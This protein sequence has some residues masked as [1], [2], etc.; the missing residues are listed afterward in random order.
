MKSSC[1][2]RF[3]T[4]HPSLKQQGGLMIIHRVAGVFTMEWLCRPGSFG[5]SFYMQ[6]CSRKDEPGMPKTGILKRVGG[7]F[8]FMLKLLLSFLLL[9]MTFGSKAQLWKAKAANSFNPYDSIGLRHNEGLEYSKTQFGVSN[10]DKTLNF[11]RILYPTLPSQETSEIATAGANSADTDSTNYVPEYMSNA[12][13]TF[14]SQLILIIDQISDSSLIDNA[15]LSIKTL[16]A[17]VLNSD[18]PEKEKQSLLCA[19]SV[20]RHSLYYWIENGGNPNDISGVYP[21]SQQ[22]VEVNSLASLSEIKDLS[23]NS[24]FNSDQELI[25]VYRRGWLRRI[26][27]VVVGDI[28]GGL[29]GAGLGTLTGSSVGI[30]AGG[31][32]GAMSGSLHAANNQGML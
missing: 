24:S 18:L 21:V 11:G 13:K 7:N 17:Q 16:E 3:L 1:G 10:L 2:F 20:A 9:I 22:A 8:L 19:S 28:V 26:L 14:S 27:R 15:S 29:V 4:P 5:S 30:L 6:A 12:G 31:F 25:A 23:N 32:F